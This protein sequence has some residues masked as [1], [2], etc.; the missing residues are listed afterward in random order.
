MLLAEARAR[1]D[2][3]NGLRDLA[4]MQAAVASCMAKNGASIAKRLH[5]NLMKQAE[6]INE[7]G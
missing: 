6:G 2:A 1:T 4:V 5:K 7:N 3:V